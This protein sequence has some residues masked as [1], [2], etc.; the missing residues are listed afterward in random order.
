MRYFLVAAA[1][2]GI[3]AIAPAAA[4]P[5]VQTGTPGQIKD[6]LGCRTL[7][8]AA[9]RLACYDRQSAAVDQA[10]AAKNLVVVD[11][12]QA[13]AARRSLFGFSL[14]NFAGLL[15]NSADEVDQIESTV[16]SAG[17]NAEGG[18][19]VALADGSMWTQTDDTPMALAPRSG[20]KI[21][22]RRRALGSFAMTVG[23]QPGVKVR[24]IS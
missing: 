7:T 16:T 22:I 18:W 20:D 11:R 13:N 10:L 8:D 9:Q 6:L 2:Y 1:A 24:R 15:G 14:P 21:V 3:L 17:R 19:T 4:R 5:P 12:E 23:R